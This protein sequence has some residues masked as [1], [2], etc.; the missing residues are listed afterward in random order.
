MASEPGYA[1]GRP[2]AQPEPEKSSGIV[3]RAWDLQHRLEHRAK[4][5]GSGRYARVL[6]MA[7]KPEPQEFRQA[8]MIVAVGLAIIGLLGFTI[9]LLFDILWNALNIR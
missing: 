3:G 9:A 1:K 6:K 7:R 5:M 2:S 4:R 8:A